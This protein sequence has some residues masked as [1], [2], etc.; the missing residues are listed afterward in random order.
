MSSYIIF[1]QILVAKSISSNF[2]C[3][4]IHILSIVSV[5]IL[6]SI[7]FEMLIFLIIVYL[8]DIFAF[9]K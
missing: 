1:I 7:V 4:T 5:L 6:R 9:K 3:L 8:L 2:V